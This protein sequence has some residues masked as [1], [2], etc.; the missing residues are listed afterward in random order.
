MIDRPILKCDLI[1]YAPQT[2]FSTNRFSEQL[3]VD[4]PR[5]TSVTFLKKILSKYI[6]MYY[7][8]AKRKKL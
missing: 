5:E 7:I 4:V 3:Y 8:E 1:P 6:F 2:K